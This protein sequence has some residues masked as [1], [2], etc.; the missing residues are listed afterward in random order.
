MHIHFIYMFLYSTAFIHYIHI[1]KCNIHVPYQ[2]SA[3]SVLSLCFVLTV[4]LGHTV[5]N[6]FLLI[7]CACIFKKLTDVWLDPSAQLSQLTGLKYFW[8]R[9]QTE[10]YIYL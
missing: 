3:N 2:K 7:T 10:K 6:S 4:M 1:M 8:Y 9:K 5:G